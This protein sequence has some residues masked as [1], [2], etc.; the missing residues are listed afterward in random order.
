MPSFL[1]PRRIRVLLVHSRRWQRR[2]IFM[3]GGLAVGLIAGGLGLA[4][5]A[6]QG[7]VFGGAGRWPYAPLALTPAGFGIAVYVATRFFPNTQGS[8]IP[9]AIAARGME[10][11]ADR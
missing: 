7:A 3:A 2:A 9:Q 1:P 10:D 11:A 4:F 6:G 8:G 5:G